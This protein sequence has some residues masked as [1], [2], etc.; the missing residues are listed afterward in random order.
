MTSEITSS[1]LVWE[2]GIVNEER[3]K[4]HTHKKC[5]QDLLVKWM[6]KRIKK[7]CRKKNEERDFVNQIMSY[8]TKVRK[9]S[10]GMIIK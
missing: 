8:F 5:P 9:H 2:K 4:F 3:K 7:G 6:G 1:C 10:T